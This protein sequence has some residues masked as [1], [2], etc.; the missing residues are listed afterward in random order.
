MVALD[1]SRASKKNIFCEEK[2]FDGK[3]SMPERDIL[4]T[5]NVI[6]DAKK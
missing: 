2:M 3:K 5:E 4:D 1:A 6:F